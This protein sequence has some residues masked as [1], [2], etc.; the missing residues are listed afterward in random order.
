MSYLAF[1]G[2]AIWFLFSRCIQMEIIWVIEWLINLYRQKLLWFMMLF[3]CLQLRSMNWMNPRS[4][5]RRRTLYLPFSLAGD[6]HQASQ[7]LWR[8][9]L[10]AWKLSRQLHETG[11]DLMI[12]WSQMSKLLLCRWKWRVWQG[13]SSLTSSAWE[14]IFNLRLLSLRKQDC[15]R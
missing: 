11:Q 15:K 6:Q 14:Q 13:G 8:G 3:M 9:D 5:F 2:F 1:H 7:L 10:A 4:V 12:S